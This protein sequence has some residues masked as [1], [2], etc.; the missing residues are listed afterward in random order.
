MG[1][2]GEGKAV[3]RLLQIWGCFICDEVWF[4]KLKQKAFPWTF[5]LCHAFQ[6]SELALLTI[7]S[8]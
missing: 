3:I 8:L 7:K 2:A 5:K 4:Q 1:I 6:A